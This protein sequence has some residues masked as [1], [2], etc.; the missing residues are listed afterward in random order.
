MQQLEKETKVIKERRMEEE[1]SRMQ[2]E[3]F[4]EKEMQEAL[5]RKEELLR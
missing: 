5:R 3:K 2:R 4:R 1:Q